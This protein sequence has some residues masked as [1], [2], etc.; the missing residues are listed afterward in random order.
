[1]G[2]EYRELVL[3]SEFMD[4]LDAP[5]RSFEADADIAPM[6][7][8]LAANLD[9][10]RA[11]YAEYRAAAEVQKLA[12][13]N[14]RLEETR[15]VNGDA[16]KALSSLAGLESERLAIVAAILEARPG[17][18]PAAGHLRCEALYPALEPAQ[19]RRLR[20][21][22]EALRKDVDDLQRLLAVN[23]AL[24]ENGS[25]IIHTTIGI[26][27]SVVGRSKTDKMSTYTKKGGVNVGKVQIRN[28][29][30]R[31]V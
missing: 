25:R 23:A 26:I 5:E 8:A 7:E 12:L 3:G 17:L 30:N 24:V 15:S 6:A 14:N 16:E 20:D 19:A 29:I 10:Q 18:A 31:S 27:T 4:L 2:S 21:S 1:M 22:R 28:L 11:V 13:I 9:A